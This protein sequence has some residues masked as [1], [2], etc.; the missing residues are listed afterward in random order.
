MLL[1]ISAL[2]QLIPQLVRVFSINV[3]LAL[4][5]VFYFTKLFIFIFFIKFKYR[6]T[7]IVTTIFLVIPYRIVI[8]P[9]KRGTTSSA[10]VW[11]VLSGTVSE[12]NHIPVPKATL[13]FEYK[14]NIVV[15]FI[16]VSYS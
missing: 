14:V 16:D 12:T 11:M 2:Q 1:I 8:V 4:Y 6:V 13:N 5:I 10:N 9:N 15:H 7:I 3:I